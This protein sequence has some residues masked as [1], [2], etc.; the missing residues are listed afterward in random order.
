MKFM[1]KTKLLLSIILL[2]SAPITVHAQP[3]GSIHWLDWTA[4]SF[5]T[6]KAENKLI[7]VNVGYEGCT[8]CRRM[9][10]TTFKDQTVIDLVNSN[11]IAIQVDSEARPDIGE[12]YSDWAW[13]ANAFMD[14]EAVQVL[15]FAGSRRPDKYIK[16]LE[17]LI[18]AHNQGT[19]TAD[20]AAPYGSAQQPA[21]TPLT[22]LRDQIR[23]TQDRA[24][25]NKSAGV[26]ENAE[27][28]RHLLL[29]HYLYGDSKAYLA[30]RTTLDG[31]TQQLDPV[32]GGVFYASFGNWG[33]VVKE[34]RLESQ[35]AALQ[36]YADG[37][38]LTGNPAYR[39]AIKNVHRY[40][41]DFM[42][43][44]DGTF[45]ASQQD[46]LNSTPNEI[47]IDDYYEL[48]D[49]GR[50]EYGTPVTD[51]AIYTDMNGRII[52]G[53]VMAFEATGDQT[54][55]DTALIAAERLLSRRKTDAGWLIQF[56]PESEQKPD[57]RI[58]VLVDEP[59]PYLRAQA[60]F[61][62]ALLALHNATADPRWAT[63]AGQLASAMF[64]TL[65][66]PE[67]GGFFGSVDDGTPGRRKPLEDNAAAARFLY[68]LGILIK[69]D[70]YKAN[71]EKVLRAAAYPGAVRRE[72]R[73]TGSLAMTLE[74]LTAGY[75]EFSVVGD[76]GDPRTQQL[77]NAARKVYEP[78]K[79]VHIEAEG[80]YPKRSAPAMY[81]CND[82][83]CTVPIFD[84]ATVSE[85]AKDFTYTAST[86]HKIAIN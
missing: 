10:Q 55:L 15:A 40:L 20:S 59:V 83:K 76:A 44:K 79:I 67:L 85:Q 35:A 19:L 32:W 41:S 17:Q 54:Y 51:H 23:A 84:P 39:D 28:L 43:S 56:I 57:Q 16:I 48:G 78:R 58:H 65:E 71:A 36:A 42:R 6:A 74:I 52:L 61:G 7:L 46:R 75:V 69:N 21:T 12:R 37:F 34:K 64:A 4:D 45:F 49:K 60:H 73:I 33:N 24:F 47:D 62:L 9:E 5:A 2:A 80:R 68:L 63:A 26:F 25:K 50:R 11:F 38:K 3:E 29:R 18:D 13:P 1:R 86:T 31:I 8:A 77:L 72:G 70:D 82:E 66:D 53:Y 81:I 22:E 27:P 14:P 30:G